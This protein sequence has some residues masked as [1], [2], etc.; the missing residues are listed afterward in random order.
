MEGEIRVSR[1]AALLEERTKC[2]LLHYMV[3][4]QECLHKLRAS[5]T[6]REA[7]LYVILL[8]LL[9]LLLCPPLSC[10]YIHTFHVTW[11]LGPLAEG[12]GPALPDTVPGMSTA[13]N[14]GEAVVQELPADSATQAGGTGWWW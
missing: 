2:T 4:H 6:V 14:L 7:R 8:L 12:E 3:A 5:L 11:E 13:T 1:E 9:L 10:R